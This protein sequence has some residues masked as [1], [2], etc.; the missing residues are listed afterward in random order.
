MDV[1]IESFVDITERKQAE[2][3]LRESEENYRTLFNSA[4][5]IIFIHDETG[6]ILAFNSLACE[7]LGYTSPELMS[8][9][10]RDVDSETD[11]LQAPE[12]IARVME[13]AHLSFETMHRRKD[14]SL[15]PTEV[16]ARHI[17]WNGRPV[18]LSICRDIT[19]RK[20]AEES[21]RQANKKLNLLS[22]ITR[23]DIKNQL[24]SLNGFLD[25]L[26]EKNPD[27]DFDRYFSRIM[28]AGNRIADMIEFTREYDMIGV[29]AP[30]WQDCRRLVDAAAK[31][32][33]LGEVTVKNDIPAG[34]E[35]YADPLIAKV[36]YNL[37]DNAA[38][39]GGKITTIRFSVQE[40][41]DNWFMLCEDDG[42][43]VPAGEKERIFDRGFGKNTGLGLALSREI[44]DITGITIRETGE[45]GKGA[46]FEMTVPKDMSRVSGKGVS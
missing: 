35:V 25:L 40:S 44:L 42:D 3:L 20:R 32:A 11:A 39:Y 29:T 34:T 26:R 19:E 13:D 7:R 41:G 9:T 46:R 6:K 5:D 45:P 15:I 22:G 14:G 38:R 2:E 12:R 31:D 28:D 30:V 24:M 36:F 17:T 33:M 21:L 16:S 4:G 27:P 10:V 43:G 1:L 23:H 18:V 37:M 8:L